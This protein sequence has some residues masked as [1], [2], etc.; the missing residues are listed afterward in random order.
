[1]TI[2]ATRITAGILAGGRGHRLG[3]RDKGWLR[4]GGRPQVERIIA[5]LQ[6]QVA[7]IRINTDR[8][9]DAYAHLAP[10][11][12]GDGEFPDCG[13]MAGIRA[14]LAACNTPYLL[15]VPVDAPHLPTNLASRLTS[16][17]H[18]HRADA[19][20]VHD[21]SAPIPVCCLLAGTLAP[22]TSAYLSAGGR[23]VNAWLQRIGTIA[24]DFSD[25][26]T[27]WSLNTPHELAT[28]R[29]RLAAPEAA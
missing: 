5:A 12:V 11:P 18:R 29:H 4:L 6:P 25:H 15:C 3:G 19:A 27:G 2:P 28:W 9:R 14:L 21:G 26:P 23:S 7:A 10:D 1:M 13:P 24:V 8:N 17:M 16:G 22:A 20:V